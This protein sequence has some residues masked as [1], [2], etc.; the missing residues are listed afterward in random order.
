[1]T[2]FRKYQHLERFGTREVEGIEHGKCYVF[3]KIDG[4][5]ASVWF[6]DK[7]IAGSRTRE[8]SATQD[9]A[10]F[11]NAIHKDENI[12]RYL[13]KYPHH[14]LYGEWLVPHSLKTY[15]ET[16]WRKFYVFDVWDGEKFL[17][18]DD[19]S[20]E[21]SYYGIEYITPICIIEN[22]TYEKF[23][24]QLP[25]NTYLI[26]D[27]KG[28]G[29][30]IV[31]KRYDFRNHQNKQVWAKIVSTE[32]KEAN[33]KAFGPSVIK[34]ERQVEDNIVQNYVTSTLIEK[35][36]SKLAID[37]WESKKIPA[38]LNIVYYSLI[39]EESWSFIK[40][41]KN[42]TINF[43]TLQAKTF[44]KVRETKPELFR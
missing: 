18:Y 10:G 41:N 24:A 22:G 21:L 9:N 33:S 44:Q 40:E 15:R 3:P 43:K 8:L 32:F 25:K 27:G 20:S 7:I 34:T 12:L 2:E 42:P 30:G 4:T 16:A 14:I 1:M 5:N 6:T 11:Y 31:I 23:V 37:G 26:E 38:L 36:Y 39:K 13:T 17:D 29:E 28:E 19:Y 35:E